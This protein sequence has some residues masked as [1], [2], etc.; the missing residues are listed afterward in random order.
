MEISYKDLSGKE[1]TVQQVSITVK[2]IKDYKANG[3]LIKKELYKNDLLV[4]EWYYIEF[5]ESHQELLSLNLQSIRICEIE[6]ID[7]NYTKNHNHTYNNSVLIKKSIS[8][9]SASEGIF[10]QVFDRDTNTP[11]YHTTIKSYNDE[12]SGY[13]FT[14]YYHSS[15]KLSSVLV[16]NDNIDFCEQYSTYDLDLIPHFEWWEKYSSYYLNADPPVPVDMVIV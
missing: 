3:R 2:Y 5:G 8:V 6:Y 12:S 7:A 13:T 9:S 14:F 1:I 11:I 15:G 16:A 4:N 10:Y